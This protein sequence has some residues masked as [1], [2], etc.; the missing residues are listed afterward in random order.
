MCRSSTGRRNFVIVA[1]TSSDIWDRILD[2]SMARFCSSVHKPLS[3]LRGVL[4][5]Q[6]V[7]A[8]RSLDL[9]DCAGVCGASSSLAE[10]SSVDCFG[11][12]AKA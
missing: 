3:R 9:L 8:S 4:S 11:G 5:D 12:H 2:H 10:P 7:G 1:Q 6:G